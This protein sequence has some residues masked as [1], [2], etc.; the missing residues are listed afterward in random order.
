MDNIDYKATDNGSVTKQLMEDIAKELKQSA[1][2]ADFIGSLVT[3]YDPNRATN[4]I[5]DKF[6]KEEKENDFGDGYEKIKDVLERDCGPD[7]KDY[8]N[9]FQNEQVMDK[10]LKNLTESDLKEL[11]PKMGPRK[12]F[13]A[14]LQSKK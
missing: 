6:E 4:W 10:D 1:K 12:R 14:W 3:K 8:L 2:Q 5:K 7:W 11:I 9:N 13:N